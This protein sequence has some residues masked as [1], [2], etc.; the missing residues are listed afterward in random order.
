MSADGRYLA[1]EFTPQVFGEPAV[2]VVDLE[3]K[4]YKVLSTA[5]RLAAL[6]RGGRAVFY[7]TGRGRGGDVVLAGLD[8]EERRLTT[9]AQILPPP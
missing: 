8:G 4:G 7:G 3:E 9:N 1:V 5:G 6:G 2:Y